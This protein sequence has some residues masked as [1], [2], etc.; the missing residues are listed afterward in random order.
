MNKEKIEALNNR[1]KQLL[2][3]GGEMA[4]QKQRDAGK[5][6]VTER[7]DALLDPDSF[8]ELGLFVKTPVPRLRHGQEGD[9]CRWRGDGYRHH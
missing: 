1:T 5:M 4:L 8:Q 9:G 7:I 3:G 6:T 2:L